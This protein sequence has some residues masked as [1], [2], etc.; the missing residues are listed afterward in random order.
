MV[1]HMDL[2]I[3]TKRQLFISCLFC[4]EGDEMTIIKCDKFRCFYNAEGICEHR[5]II[6]K[7]KRCMSYTVSG[8]F[9]I[10]DL[11]QHKATCHKSNGKY[12]NNTAKVF[13]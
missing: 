2:S 3:T 12:K 11:V 13:K 8:S 9:T 6:M 7:Y 5:K 4:L 10:R 1:T